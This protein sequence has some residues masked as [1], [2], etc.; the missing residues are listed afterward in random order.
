MPLWK[1][2]RGK[3]GF[4]QPLLGTWRA[5]ADSPMGPIRC[6]RTFSETLNG[7]YI[8]VEAKWT[9]GGAKGK[10]YEE[11]ALIGVD[12]E[13]VVRYWSF[14]SDG[15][16]SHGRVADVSALHPEAIGFALEMPAGLARMAYWP[17]GDGG[18]VW[19]VE[20]RNAR[21]WRRF[22]EHKYRQLNT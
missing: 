6:D 18:L 21:G 3:L 7:S 11:L 8:R 10:R 5:T 20:S 14:T 2:G 16:N 9:I 22:A 15:K 19:V 13:K 12:R 17:D 1:K 4:L